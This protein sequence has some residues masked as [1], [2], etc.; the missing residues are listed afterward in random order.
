MKGGM[1]LGVPGTPGGCLHGLGELVEREIV[2]TAD[3]ECL[4][5]G[6]WVDDGLLDDGGDVG[7]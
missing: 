1:C 5:A 3:L 6:G 7:D 4:A 2:R